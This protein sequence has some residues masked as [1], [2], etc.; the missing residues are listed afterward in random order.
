MA[1]ALGALSRLTPRP[2]GRFTGGD[3]AR[4]GGSRLAERRWE[5]VRD[6]RSCGSG[7]IGGVSIR[8]PPL[9]TGR[10][11]DWS[12]NVRAAIEPELLARRRVC[13]PIWERTGGP[14]VVCADDID[15][16]R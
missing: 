3:I 2:D 13:A 9:D 15:D 8:G 12:L 10:R 5:A 4:V 16:C 14:M 11:G 6:G 7:G 1:I